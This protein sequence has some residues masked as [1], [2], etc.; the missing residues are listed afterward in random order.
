[1]TGT[2]LLVPA[3]EYHEAEACMAKVP[4]RLLSKAEQ[5]RKRTGCLVTCIE[6]QEAEI[7][8]KGDPRAFMLRAGEV[9][10]LQHLATVV[11]HACEVQITRRGG[12]DRERIDVL[13]SSCRHAVC[14]THCSLGSHRAVL[15]QN[16]TRPLSDRARVMRSAYSRSPPMGR[17]LARRVMEISLWSLRRWRI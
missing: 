2:V 5:C 16:L 4:V 13:H 15:L 6:Y 1:M 10:V 7:E 12:S 8:Q 14:H 11:A 3:V 17:P 9:A